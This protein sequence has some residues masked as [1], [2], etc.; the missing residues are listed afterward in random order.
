VIS[1]ELLPRNNHWVQDPVRFGDV[2][3][4]SWA[5]KPRELITEPSV[6]RYL[7]P[8]ARE[9]ARIRVFEKLKRGETQQRWVRASK[10]QALELILDLKVFET[11]PDHFLLV[12]DRGPVATNVF[13]QRIH[14]FALDIRWLPWPVLPKRQR[15][16]VEYGVKRAITWDEHWQIVDCEQN[17]EKK[18]FMS[19]AGF[20]GG[21]QGGIANLNAEDIEDQPN[22]Q[23]TK[24]KLFH[25]PE[26][27]TRAESVERD[28]R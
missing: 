4:N 1:I 21:S 15:P 7:R 9:W 24:V 23:P 6:K 22:S 26:R 10:D 20:L 18:L 17:P 25:H 13:L 16:K 3:I 12:L 28:K 14:N 27:R 8:I 11:Q 5:A 2:L 19:S